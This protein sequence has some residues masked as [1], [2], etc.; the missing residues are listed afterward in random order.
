MEKTTTSDTSKN[1][2][3]HLGGKPIKQRFCA[4]WIHQTLG[5]AR[6]IYDDGVSN[7]FENAHQKGLRR[8]FDLGWSYKGRFDRAILRDMRDSLD[9]KADKVFIRHLDK[10]IEVLQQ[11]KNNKEFI[12]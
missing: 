4:E 10:A 1:I 7:E 11:H 12:T 8:G 3:N 9:P 6:L 5:Q 2:C